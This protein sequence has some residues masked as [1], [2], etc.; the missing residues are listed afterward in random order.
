M[1][2]MICGK[3]QSEST[4]YQGG[5]WACMMCGNRTPSRW[6]FH[7]K[8]EE[9]KTPEP[10]VIHEPPLLEDE[11]I[12]QEEMEMSKMGDCNNCDRNNIEI[13]AH[14]RC[15]GCSDA[16][17][18]APSGKQDEALARYAEKVKSGTLRQ[19]ASGGGQSKVE[20]KPKAPKPAALTPEK[21][22]QLKTKIRAR[23][24]EKI[25]GK[26]ATSTDGEKKIEIP[27]VRMTITPEDP[28]HALL[29]FT[30]EEN[31]HLYEP[32][33]KYCRRNF[34]RAP[35]DQAMQLIE[36]VLTNEGLI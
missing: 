28:R 9:I 14:G 17:Y 12:E 20:K 4:Y 7:K 26:A 6:G 34:R 36:E 21:R 31:K 19:R 15:R 29:D 13:I 22:E 2:S 18:K 35:G 5:G 30:L 25:E 32:W 16:W 27:D 1:G 10:I 8:G 11:D 3:C 33:E 23:L 24:A